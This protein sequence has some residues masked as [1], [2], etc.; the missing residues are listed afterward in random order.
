MEEPP[1]GLIAGGS[2]V[3]TIAAIAIFLIF[4]GPVFMGIGAAT[5]FGTIIAWYRLKKKW[6]WLAWVVLAIG[7]VFGGFVVFLGHC[8]RIPRPGIYGNRCSNLFWHNYCLVSP[9]EEMGMVGLGCFSHRIGFW[10]ICCIPG[11]R[12]SMNSK[13]PKLIEP[14]KNTARSAHKFSKTPIA[15]ILHYYRWRC[16]R[17][18]HPTANT[19]HAA[20]P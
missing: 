14:S 7:L 4:P 5:S 17:A 2:A 1:W 10:R 15:F 9:K 13:T 3:I 12:R 6:G 8:H 16:C 18:M 11:S 20:P 19:T